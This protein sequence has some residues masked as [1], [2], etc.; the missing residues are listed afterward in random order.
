MPFS[1]L[2]GCLGC[3]LR[4]RDMK[5]GSVR[6]AEGPLT[7]PLPAVG[8]FVDKGLGWKIHRISEEAM[9]IV[10]NL[11]PNPFKGVW[12]GALCVVEASG[13]GSG[14]VCT[15]GDARGGRPD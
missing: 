1:T 3:S 13:Q 6:E 10:A 9:L 7:I 15:T 14:R 12:N 8:R 11:Q 4:R 5:L 2:S